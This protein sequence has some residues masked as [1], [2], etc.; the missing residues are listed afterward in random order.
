MTWN[1]KELVAFREN[2]KNKRFLYIPE[3]E[4]SDKLYLEQDGAV[5]EYGLIQYFV[6]PYVLPEGQLRT[7]QARVVTRFAKKWRE[8]NG[9]TFNA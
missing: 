5:T 1:Y 6:P 2:D 9:I 4:G 3:G 8:D 7:H